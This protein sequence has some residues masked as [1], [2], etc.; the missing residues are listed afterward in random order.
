MSLKPGAMVVWEYSVVCW[1]AEMGINQFSIYAMVASKV[2]L[3]SLKCYKAK[4]ILFSKTYKT[5]PMASM[6][7]KHFFMIQS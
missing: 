4:S 7:S 6:T 2:F 5:E 1:K 3:E